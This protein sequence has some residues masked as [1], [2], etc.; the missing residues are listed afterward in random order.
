MLFVYTLRFSF[1]FVSEVVLL[2]IRGTYGGNVQKKINTD[3]NDET[4]RVFSS[5]GV[6]SPFIY[7]LS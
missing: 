2:A 4:D 5:N 6:F 3:V 7:F 1:M